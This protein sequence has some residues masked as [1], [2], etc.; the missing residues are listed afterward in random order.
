MKMSNKYIDLVIMTNGNVCRAPG[1]SDIQPGYK[2]AVQGCTYDVLEVAYV[3]ES[4]ALLTLPR[5]FGCMI[6]LEYDE[7]EQEEEANV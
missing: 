4:E 1:F 5:V 2:V 3:P 7:D 6:P